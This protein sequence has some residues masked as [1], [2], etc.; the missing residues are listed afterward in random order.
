MSNAYLSLGSNLGDKKKNIDTA[1]KLLRENAYIRILE[2]SSVYETEP[3]GYTEQ[4]LFYNIVIKIETNLS[5]IELLE[6]CNS[7][8]MLLKRER[9]IKWGPRTMDI[10]I[11][12][13]DDVVIDDEKLT[14]PHPRIAER[15]FVLVPLWEIANYITINGKK[16]Q[17]LLENIDKKGIKKLI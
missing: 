4:D 9:I 11:L 2:L 15:A 6:Y 5:P 3:V 14:I 13:F 1:L 12:L 17:D 8:E 7:I 10:D 16:I